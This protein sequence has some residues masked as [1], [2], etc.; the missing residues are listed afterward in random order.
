MQR[1]ARQKN[2]KAALAAAFVMALAT[3]AGAA[4]SPEPGYGLPRDVS[5][6]GHHIDWLIEVTGVFTAIL[7]V[8]MVVWMI[9]A[10][11]QHNEK[12]EAEYDHGASKHSIKTAVLL[13]AVI[14]FVVDGNLFYNSTT[15]T[16]RLFWNHD[17]VENNPQAVKIQI[18]AHQWAWDARYAG[19]DGKFNTKDDVITLND[20]RVPVGA[21]VLLQMVSPDVIHS[22]Y[23][24]NLRIKQD[25]MPGMINRMWFQAKQTGEFEIGCAQHCGVNHYKMKGILTVLTPEEFKTWATE[26]SAIGVRGFDPKDTEAHWGWEWRARN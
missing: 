10:C 23:L 2:G 12:H 21:P 7:F 17:G 9:W 20:I 22:F 25:A 1:K 19:P 18:N 26:Q 15:D 6:Y 11:L 4:P 3:A 24:P 16:F 14:F 8:I 13:S 5:E